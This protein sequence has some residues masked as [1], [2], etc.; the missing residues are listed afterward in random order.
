MVVA[1]TNHLYFT[2]E[3]SPKKSERT[4]YC[5]KVKGGYT[6]ESFKD[7][8]LPTSIVCALV[9]ASNTSLAMTTWASYKTVETH[10]RRCESDTKVKI[11]F[12]MDSREVY[13]N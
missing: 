6:S 9:T 11:R 2:G 5:S 10:L 1:N 8:R 3:F 13:F 12:P 7:Y 4:K